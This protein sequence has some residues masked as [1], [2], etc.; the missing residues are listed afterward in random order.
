MD[1]LRFIKFSVIKAVIRIVGCI[2][3]ALF[4]PDAVMAV[5]ILGLSFIIADLIGLARDLIY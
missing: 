5:T 3:A 2:V 1:N 4:L